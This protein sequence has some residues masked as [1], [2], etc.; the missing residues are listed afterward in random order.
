MSVSSSLTGRPTPILSKG[1]SRLRDVRRNNIKVAVWLSESLKTMLG[2]KGMNKMLVDV[3]GKPLITNDGREALD[4][5]GATNPVAKMII[6]IARTQDFVAGD[7]TKT[8][9]ILA[10]E[11]LKKAEKLLNQKVHPIFIIKGYEVA[12]KKALTFLDTL[13]TGVSIEDEAT[14]KKLVKTVIGGRLDEDSK[15]HLTNLIVTAAKTIAEEKSGKIVVDPIH[16]D[17]KKQE[18]KS[19]KDTELVSGLVLTRTKP[20][21]KMP[22]KIEN[23]K[24]ALV[25]LPLDPHAHRAVETRKIIML[26]RPEDLKGISDMAIEHAQGIV[27]QVKRAGANVLCCRKTISDLI[28]SCF[29]DAGILALNL[30]SEEDL[31]RLEKATGAKIVMSMNELTAED[32]GQAGLAEYRSS[33]FHEL[34]FVDRCKD[35]RAVTI[36]V[37]GG[38]VQMVA[39]IERIIKDCIKA[40]SVAIEAGKVISGGGAA[41]IEIARKLRALSRTYKGKEQLAIEAFAEAVETIP[42]TLASNAGL[43]PIDVLVEL[44][45]GHANGNVNLGVNGLGRKVEDMAERGCLDAFTVKQHAIKVSCE[46]AQMIL[47]ID[48]AVAATNLKVIK[49]E[50]KRK[51]DEVAFKTNERVIE[52]SKNREEFK[53]LE[54]FDKEL[55]YRQEHPE[56]L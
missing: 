38:T 8:S 45:S 36:L 53:E 11:L 46:I 23:P 20:H 34:L 29:A 35:P 1:Y 17:I 41:E 3:L 10:G 21:I 55:D 39:E 31:L 14:L 18:G 24:I 22:D 2:P 40:I 16:L 48:D 6:E 25:K 56:V 42:R 44:R 47:R 33:S 19:V 50:K 26:N 28:L 51:E 9:V 30:V 52:A 12:S 43:D 49:A 27:N 32:L 7:G 4:N 54:K 5:M 37:R 15:N 13:A